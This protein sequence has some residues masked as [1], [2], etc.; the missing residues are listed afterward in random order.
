MENPIFAAAAAARKIPTRPASLG[1]TGR[2][3]QNMLDS[4]SKKKFV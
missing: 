4:S 1:A 3:V 2:F